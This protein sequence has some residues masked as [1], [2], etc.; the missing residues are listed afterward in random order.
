MYQGPARDT[1]NIVLTRLF[2]PVSM[3]HNTRDR[4]VARLLFMLSLCVCLALGA[5]TR[6]DMRVAA[7]VEE[8][9]NTN[10]A[11]VNTRV[12]KC[13]KKTGRAT[14]NEKPPTDANDYVTHAG[15]CAACTTDALRTNRETSL[16]AG[17]NDAS[18]ETVRI[19]PGN[20]VEILEDTVLIRPT[21]GTVL[22][23]G[24]DLKTC[25][26]VYSVHV[27][28]SE[29]ERKLRVWRDGDLIW[30]NPLRG[31]E[32]DAGATIHWDGQLDYGFDDNRWLRLRGPGGALGW[33]RAND[34]D[35]DCMWTN[36][37]YE[38]GSPTVGTAPPT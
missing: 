8:S 32:I 21:R 12:P 15:G 28:Y 37:K 36:D 24:G 35:F 25:D 10:A 3:K 4:L 20:W 18:P 23:A 17:A 5:C 38:S 13:R 19:G 34:G 26:V 16:L 30:I 7:P 14:S 6:R 27:E 9:A 29:N 31:E 22:V 33:A 1:I 11:P 2:S